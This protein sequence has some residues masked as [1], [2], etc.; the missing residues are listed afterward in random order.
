MLCWRACVS[1][2]LSQAVGVASTLVGVVFGS[3]SQSFLIKYTLLRYAS[4]GLIFYLQERHVDTLHSKHVVR[5]DEAVGH[6]SLVAH[7]HRLV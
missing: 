4:R 1:F 6:Q 2:F 7:Q 3:G 5:Q